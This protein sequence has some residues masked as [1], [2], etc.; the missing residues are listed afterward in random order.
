[1]A[2]LE[3][4]GP[5][6]AKRGDRATGDEPEKRKL[7]GLHWVALFGVVAVLGV[8]GWLAFGQDGIQPGMKRADVDKR[9]GPPNGK[10]L[11]VAGTPIKETVLV[12][13]DRGLVIEFDEDDRV[14]EVTRPPTLLH[15]L[16]SK[17]GF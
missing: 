3:G 6:E 7:R 2:A 15:N 1:M 8:F 13:K 16:R 4:Q 12:W 14:R 10:M 5:D 17:L 11:A 9:L